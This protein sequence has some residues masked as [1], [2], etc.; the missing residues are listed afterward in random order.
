MKKDDG[1]G[2]S[3]IE[4]IEEAARADSADERGAR[5]R[6]IISETQILADARYERPQYTAWKDGIGF[7]PRGNIIMLSAEKKHG[8]TFV[9]AQMAA[10]MIGRTESDAFCLNGMYREGGPLRVAYFDTEQDRYDAN[11]TQKRI[12]YMGRYGLGEESPLYFFNVREKSS[13]ERLEA[14]E[15]VAEYVRADVVFIDGVRD[16]IDDF[17][18]IEQSNGLVN[19]LLGLSSRLMCAI[20]CILHVNPGSDKMRGHLGTELGNK[21]TD[22]FNVKKTRAAEM[23]QPATYTVTHTDSRHRDIDDWR[24]VIDNEESRL[25][26]PVLTGSQE[27][28]E[29]LRADYEDAGWLKE[30]FRALLEKPI[31]KKELMEALCSAF[32]MRTAAACKAIEAAEEKFIVSKYRE[33]RSIKYQYNANFA[34]EPKLP[35]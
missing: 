1:K 8:K 4:L 24:F 35:F 21:A 20:W 29:T 11:L 7:A 32:G 3:E 28:R 34:S 13:A 26:I 33:G 15:V 22:I 9:F 25:G 16:L 12:L 2:R 30:A 5:A 17:N 27:L 19:R 14:V 18:D 6:S 10:L 31:G 23:G